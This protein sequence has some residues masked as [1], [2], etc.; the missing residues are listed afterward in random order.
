MS[1]TGTSI[2]ETIAA[3]EAPPPEEKVEAAPQAEEISEAVPTAEGADEPA[4]ATE[5]VEAEGTEDEPEGETPEPAP[6]DPPRF[7]DA[8]KKALFSDMPREL[9]EYVLSKESERDKATSKAIEEAAGKRKAADGEA[10]RMAQYSTALDKLIPQAAETFQSRWANVDWNTVVDTYG[11]EE[12]LKLRNNFEQES[13][14]LQQLQTAK[15][16]AD[17][18]QFAKFVEI[19]SGKLGEYC[20]ELTDPKEG[21]NRKVELGKF[22]VTEGIPESSIRHMT[23]KETSLA[24]DAYRWRQ[25]Q[26]KAVTMANKPKPAAPASKVAVR[27]TA[28]VSRGTTETARIRSL[29][30][31]FAQ[32]PSV[33]NLEALLNAKGE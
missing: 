28:S 33:K 21:N 7:W 15:V 3:L 17:N 18:I 14:T 6:L 9:Q 29:E 11:A 8:E 26:A 30:G 2:N 31:A 13:R 19:E 20:P 32:N 10:L 16:E 5:G 24:Y 23:A 4:G 12:A 27:P 1:D 25:A 22:L